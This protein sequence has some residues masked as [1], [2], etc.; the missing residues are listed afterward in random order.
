MMDS[1]NNS[2]DSCKDPLLPSRAQLLS[3]AR[4]NTT[5]IS[6]KRGVSLHAARA[7]RKASRR[8]LQTREGG[9]NKPVLD[10]LFTVQS[11]DLSSFVKETP[12]ERLRPKSLLF[13]LLNPRSRQW[14]AIWFKSFISTVILV[15][16]IIFVL[17]TEPNLSDEQKTL[18]HTWEGATSTIFLIEYLA[19]I[20]AV[21]EAKKYGEF[22]PF[23]GRVHFVT[24]MASIVDALAI[25]PFFLELVTGWNL[26]TLTFLR[27][28]RLLRILKTNGMVRATDAVYRVIYYN[29]QIL[30]VALFVC[31]FMI[32]VTSVLMYYLRP[33]NHQNSQGKNDACLNSICVARHLFL[34]YYCLSCS[35]QSFSPFCRPCTSP[36]SC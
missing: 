36:H 15:D 24:N 18:C 30:Y 26:P 16:L 8:D 6:S 21:I 10:Q 20:Y 27:A 17:S 31:I 32:L 29:R 11:R 23:W 34:L 19:R 33:R 5:T 1:K 3:N 35:L 22:G 28:F 2:D 25:L 4:A 12:S 14:Q 9:S 13:T 7:E